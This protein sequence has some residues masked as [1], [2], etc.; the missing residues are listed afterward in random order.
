[1]PPG[2][3]L[4]AGER[5]PVGRCRPQSPEQVDLRLK[6]G[7]RAVDTSVVPPGITDGFT[8]K[9]PDLGTYELGAVLPHCGPR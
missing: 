7:S 4:D 2:R 8:G 9:A 1:M 5:N 3:V 6:T